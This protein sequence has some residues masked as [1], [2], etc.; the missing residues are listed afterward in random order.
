MTYNIKLAHK[1][2]KFIYANRDT[3]L[4]MAS[5]AVT[6]GQYDLTGLGGS[7][8]IQATLSS[9]DIVLGDRIYHGFFYPSA[10]CVTLFTMQIFVN[11]TQITSQSEIIKQPFSTSQ[12]ATSNITRSQPL[13]FSWVATAG[14]ILSI[15]YTKPTI[16]T[17][18]ARVIYNKTVGTNLFMMEVEK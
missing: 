18:S 15:R 4:T 6:N 16:V 9:G 11:G 2:V 5:G 12:I 13:F 1:N 10:A 14:D 7:T 8:G 3:D 17:G